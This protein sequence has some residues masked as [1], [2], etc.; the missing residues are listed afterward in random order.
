MNVCK[1]SDLIGVNQSQCCD[2][3]FLP[4]SS[5]IEQQNVAV[6]LTSQ[7]VTVLNQS[8]A[9]TDI[10]QALL[11]VFTQWL[12]GNVSSHL[13]VPFVV[14]ACRNMAAMPNLVVLLESCIEAYFAS[15]WYFHRF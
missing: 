4:V 11:T 9:Q 5:P 2:C 15:G 10:Q 7:L 13:V 6:M 12:A 8:N 14:S 1:R 3:V